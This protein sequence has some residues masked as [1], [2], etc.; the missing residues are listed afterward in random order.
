MEESPTILCSTD[1]DKPWVR[2]REQLPI[3]STAEQARTVLGFPFG[4]ALAHGQMRESS[5]GSTTKSARGGSICEDAQNNC[6]TDCE[7]ECN[8]CENV[9]IV[10]KS[11]SYSH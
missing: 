7:C 6:C 4:G 9:L 2:Q 8:T 1:E 10:N 11:L 3:N 5:R